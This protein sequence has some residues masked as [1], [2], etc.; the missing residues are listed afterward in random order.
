[1]GPTSEETTVL[2]S[3]YWKAGKLCRYYNTWEGCKNGGHCKFMHANKQD[4]IQDPMVQLE[5]ICRFYDTYEG[6]KRGRHCKFRH[7][8][9]EKAKL[10]PESI[11]PDLPPE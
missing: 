1:M 4:A 7:V 2:T 11:I 9:T 5:S 3:D 6:C 10:Q 8:K